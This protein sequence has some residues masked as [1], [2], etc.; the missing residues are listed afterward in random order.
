MRKGMWNMTIWKMKNK[1]IFE[2]FVGKWLPGDGNHLINFTSPYL[3]GT[4]FVALQKSTH[5]ARRRTQKVFGGIVFLQVVHRPKT[6]L[7]EHLV[8]PQGF[9]MCEIVGLHLISLDVCLLGLGISKHRWVAWQTWMCSLMYTG[10]HGR[11]VASSY[12][13]SYFFLFR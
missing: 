11:Y 1:T 5:R 9:V 7:E 12:F 6:V 4:S 13:P 3:I 2:D 10:E 8:M